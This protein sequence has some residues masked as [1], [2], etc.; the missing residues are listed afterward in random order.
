MSGEL[1]TV[2]NPGLTVY[3]HVLSPAGLRW[4]GSDFEAYTAVDL[5]DYGI[6]VSEQGSSGVYVGDFPSGITTAAAYEI[7][8]FSQQGGSAAEGDPIVGTGDVEWSGTAEVSPVVSGTAA[9]LAEEAWAA[10]GE[11]DPTDEQLD[12]A[13]GEW[14]QEVFNDIWLEGVATGNTRLKILQETLIDVSVKGT[15]TWDLNEDMDEELEIE[16][17]NGSR[18]STAQAGGSTS[19]TLAA[20][21]TGTESGTVGRWILITSGTGVNEIKQ[22]TDFN[23]TTK[24]ATVDSAWSGTPTSSSTYLVVDQE[25]QL[26]EIDL[27]EMGTAS[28]S[29][30]RPTAFAKYNRQVLFDRP[31]DRSTYGIRLRYFMNIHSVDLTDGAGT[32]I[33]RIY[34]NWRD[35]L[36]QGLLW[37]ALRSEDDQRYQAEYTIFK[38][39]TAALLA[40]EIPYGGAFKGFSV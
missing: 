21:D 25:I 24:V 29:I 3:A 38:S 5:S 20:A 17:L 28:M 12:R 39:K 36:I 4:N 27:S 31:W 10:A 23:S 7:I 1:K 9:D 11:S 16:V 32:R 15:R 34:T 35:V 26:D 8:F 19:I 14:M 40:K 18:Y 22:V 37:K 33:R 2:S 30:G 13:T 6:S